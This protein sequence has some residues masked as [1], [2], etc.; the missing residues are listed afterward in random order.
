MINNVELFDELD[1]IEIKQEE[2]N[3]KAKPSETMTSLE[4]QS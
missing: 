2:E 1:G 4:N 3:L